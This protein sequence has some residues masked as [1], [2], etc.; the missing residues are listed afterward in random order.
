MIFINI[1]LDIHRSNIEECEIIVVEDI[2]DSGRTLLYLTQYL[3]NK[4]AKSVRTCTL[5]DKP[6]RRVVEFEAD[7]VGKVIPD[8]FVVGYGLDY[9]EKYRSLPYVGVLKPSAY[10]N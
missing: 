1:H 5:L 3:M 4:G 2:V 7:Y 6:C 8:G 10:E 9:D